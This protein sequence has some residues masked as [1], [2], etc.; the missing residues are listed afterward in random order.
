MMQQIAAASDVWLGS[1]PNITHTQFAT[2]PVLELQ[3][4]K[5][6]GWRR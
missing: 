2:S 6:T 5:I 3:K 4:Y 1:W